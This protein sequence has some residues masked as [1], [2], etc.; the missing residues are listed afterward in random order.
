MGMPRPPGRGGQGKIGS[1][2]CADELGIR[3]GILE[4][5]ARDEQRLRV[6]DAR[7][8]RGLVLV[9]GVERFLHGLIG[10]VVGI[11]LE[12]AD[13]ADVRRCAGHA[14]EIALH[15]ERDAALRAQAHGTGHELI[16]QA[17]GRDLVAERLLDEVEQILVLGLLGLGLLLLFLGLEAEVVGRNVA[18]GL[19]A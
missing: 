19:S 4:R 1:D 7:D 8:A 15:L 12:H 17:H 3:G 11:E 13:G 9:A 16:G 18:N 5:L 2:E 14:L 10:V 6:Q